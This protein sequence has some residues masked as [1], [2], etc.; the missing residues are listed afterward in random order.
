[1][2]YNIQNNVIKT[3]L[4]ELFAVIIYFSLFNSYILQ[5][6]VPGS[7]YLQCTEITH[8]QQRPRHKCTRTKRKLNSPGKKTKVNRVLGNEVK[9]TPYTE[10]TVVYS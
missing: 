5:E 4:T 7:I 6:A 9:K 1:M 10:C 3:L 2:T 8:T